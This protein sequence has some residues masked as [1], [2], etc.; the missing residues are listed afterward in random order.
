MP[1]RSQ[2]TKIWQLL[3]I[4]LLICLLIT[5]GTMLICS[6]APRYD[7]Q[8][9]YLL[10]LGQIW[11]DTQTELLAV[12][13]RRVSTFDQLARLQIRAREVA[14]VLSQSRL[15]LTGIDPCVAQ[16]KS[17]SNLL[18][19]YKTL[20]SRFSVSRSTTT[21][22]ISNA[23]A[24]LVHSVPSS[25]DPEIFDQ[26]K[27]TLQ[28]YGQHIS[29]SS[30]GQVN[31]SELIRP[32]TD[33]DLTVI[34]DSRLA[35]SLERI[36]KCI[37]DISLIEALILQCVQ[38]MSAMDFR[39]KLT[40]ALFEIRFSRDYQDNLR[41]LREKILIVVS[42][43]TIVYL[44]IVYIQ[45]NKAQQQLDV[46]NYQ[47]EQL[48]ASRTQ[49]LQQQRNFNAQILSSLPNPV[50]WKDLK[51]VY[52][53]C[54]QA[55]C[56]LAEVN[57]VQDII[58]RTDA[59]LNWDEKTLL[60]KST[61][62]SAV[63]VGSDTFVDFD[64]TKRLQSGSQIDLLASKVPLRDTAGNIS[65]VLGVYTDVTSHRMLQSK[66]AQAQKLESIGQLAAGIAHEINSPMQYVVSNIT[67]LNEF[68]KRLVP[69]LNSYELIADENSQVDLGTWRQDIQELK[70]ETKF[71][72]FRNKVG[73]AINDCIEGAQR[74]TSIV[75]AMKEFSHPG[76]QSFTL[77]NINEIL[78]STATVTR[79]RWKY[80]SNILWDLDESLPEVSCLPSQLGQVFINLII[81]A[82]DAISD[83]RVNDSEDLGQISIRTRLDGERMVR[84]EIEDNGAGMS[85]EILPRIFDPF[86][87]TKE[88][89]KGTGQ[90]LSITY[91][92]VV[93]KHHGH[94][95]V[96]S[97]PGVGTQFIIQLPIQQLVCEELLCAH[98]A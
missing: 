89:G 7:L 32:L 30:Y 38:D 35:E 44:L 40:S 97:S 78:Q 22:E 52:Q 61:L 28:R 91:D 16:I 54:N 33:L 67:F 83:S 29:L 76:S 92:I 26:L 18:D 94:I 79:N 96:E 69:V 80:V 17:L 31:T 82:A 75:R 88:V 46:Y 6:H 34:A 2:R 58:G 9:N 23:L 65:G 13:C 90:G 14:R 4:I 62:D 81:N 24:L 98:N 19:D 70:E 3:P 37:A 77:S 47:L 42:V 68:Y 51:G 25:L 10:E 53:G 63:A 1:I 15:D 12:Q 66:L 21:G 87:T 71:E 5:A 73:D 72:K 27:D 84:I 8:E 11:N 95:E 36:Q 48:V 85:E 74:V 39:N 56:K 50:F 60:L 86:F 43:S 57:T 93:N 55:Y 64:V 45:L 20:L 41:F 59:D 49:H